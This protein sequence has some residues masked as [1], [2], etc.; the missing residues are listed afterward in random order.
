M[1]ANALRQSRRE[2]APDRTSDLSVA[3]EEFERLRQPPRPVG[4]AVLM[5]FRLDIAQGVPAVALPAKDPGQRARVGER[6][7]A[8][9]GAD[10][11]VDAPARLTRRLDELE[12]PAFAEPD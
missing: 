1:M 4:L 5:S 2:P 10:V 12:N 6:L 11:G 8:L 9:R 3:Q 7:V